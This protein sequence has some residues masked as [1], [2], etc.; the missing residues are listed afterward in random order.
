M[1]LNYQI[2]AVRLKAMNRKSSVILGARQTARIAS[3]RLIKD[4]IT[5]TVGTGV[6]GAML[7]SALR[8]GAS[9]AITRILA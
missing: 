2:L 1:V 9:K 3:N 6:F 8:A 5:K 4:S 7:T